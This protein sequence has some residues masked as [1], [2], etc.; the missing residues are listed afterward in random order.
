[1][2]KIKCYMGDSDWWDERFKN[3]KK[4]IMLPEKRLEQDNIYFRKMKT[5]L[6][7]ACGDGRNS[8]YFAQNGYDVVAVDFSVEALKR[9]KF[10][11][12]EK[13]LAIETKLVNVTS[14]D[15]LSSIGV[16][17]DAVVVNHYR[18]VNEIYPVLCAM[19]NTNGILWV[20]G[21]ASVPQDNPNIKET[22]ILQ[23]SDF[24]LISDCELL[25]KEYYAISERK[26][27]R[28]IWKKNR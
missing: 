1:M 8:F 3:R 15:E 18:P 17:V 2:T 12:E 28:Y 9:L 25:S 20:N 21:F 23:D 7:L 24:E 10:F 16:K 5:I 27:V 22:D 13:S 4:E 6:D 14:I 26:F 11:A 19:L